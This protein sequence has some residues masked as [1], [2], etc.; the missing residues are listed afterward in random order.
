MRRHVVLLPVTALVWAAAAAAAPLDR[1]TLERMDALALGW[2]TA[3]PRTRFERWDAGR[4]ARLLER[5]RSFGT[6]PEG[7]LER[8]RDRL[9]RV[10]VRRQLGPRVRGRGKGVIETP[11]GEAWFRVR[12]AGRDKGLIIGLHG[13]GEGV[14]SADSATGWAARGCMGMYPQA[15]LLHE[16]AWNTVHGEKFILTMIDIAK[17][18]YGVDPDRVYVMGFSMG[19][20]GSW[21]MA[22][23]HPDLLAGASPCHGVLMAAPKSQVPR[24]EDV[25]ALQYGIV[26]NVRNL[27]MYYYT[28]L[29][30]KNCM[31]GTYLYVWDV[32]RELQEADPGGYR[33]IR[34]RVY[35]EVAHSFPPG[36]PRK[37]I[38]WLTKQRREAFPRKVVWQNALNPHPLPREE[39]R[40]GRFVKRFFY[41][42]QC[43]SPPDQVTVEAVRRG[44]RFEIS[45]G[46]GEPGD[47][48]LLLNPSMIDVEKEVV[49][50][51]DDEE[52]YRGRPEPDFATVLET[53][54]ARLD[55]TLTFDRRIRLGE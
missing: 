48:H 5:A 31:P 27:A 11:Y 42:I 3:R 7:S 45:L 43:T 21:F 44:N 29:R 38:V 19:G 8:V 54:D 35:P 24:K 22:G 30:D 13:G 17:V 49:V 52:I 1:A 53:L 39:D 33:K 15:I 4:R 2:W 14:G 10:L 12:S 51:V 28:G 9:W 25:V 41:W 20:T 16:D 40:T 18:Q 46:G 55:R 32:L 23:R 6:I 50:V 37:G 36:E 47:F 34:F 26:P